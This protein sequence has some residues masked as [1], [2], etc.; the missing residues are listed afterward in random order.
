MPSAGTITMTVGADVGA[1]DAGVRQAERIYERFSAATQRSIDSV[2]RSSEALAAGFGSTSALMGGM[3]QTVKV[4]ERIETQTAAASRS[5]AGLARSLGTAA[6]GLLML[7]GNAE[8]AS[9]S[10]GGSLTKAFGSFLA[11]G[12]GV[13]GGVLAAVSLVADGI[14]AIGRN[15]AESAEKVT[16]MAS[17]LRDMKAPGSTLNLVTE[18]EAAQRQRELD[19]RA[20]EAG[21]SPERFGQFEALQADRARE[22]AFLKT[23]QDAIERLNPKL[24]EA[25]K[26][27]DELREAGSPLQSSAKKDLDAL[28]KQLQTAQALAQGAGSRIMGIDEQLPGVKQEGKEE[29]RKKAAEE[30]KKLDDEVQAEWLRDLNERARAAEKAAAEDTAR[31]EAEESAREKAAADQLKHEADLERMRDRIKKR[32]RAAANDVEEMKRATRERNEGLSQELQLRLA[33]TDMERLQLRHRFEYN[34]ELSKGTDMSAVIEIH[35]RETADLLAAQREE[36][37]KLAD[38]EQERALAHER[39][40][41]E[42]KNRAAAEQEASAAIARMAQ[43]NAFGAGYGPLAQARD[44]KKRNSNIARFKNHADNLR[45]ESPLGYGTVGAP[46][47]DQQGNPLGTEYDP[48][49]GAILKMGGAAD[50]FAFDMGSVFSRFHNPPKPR[51]DNAAPG[52]LAPPPPA[53]PGDPAGPS[54]EDI[55]G[56]LGTASDAMKGAADRGA[57]AAQAVGEAADALDEAAGAVEDGADATDRLAG[58]TKDLAAAVGP[59]FEAARA[60]AEEALEIARSVQ[61]LLES[62]GFYGS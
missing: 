6:G 16:L 57:A 44:A 39:M 31:R 21:M 56:P 20:A 51:Y 27:Y 36:T 54:M 53:Q 2:M 10:I 61:S 4:V 11:G 60:T 25:R 14:S 47:F 34:A 38:A 1:L 48:E 33:S 49:S 29:F 45:A 59:A 46:Q 12:G 30:Q 37:E 50:P 8:G 26:L 7:S 35:A 32:D 55:Y 22:A 24:A 42:A 58:A 62:S 9:Q 41:R 28:E 15:A 3:T 23:Q 40:A 5:T 19:A 17:R 18:R 13:S 43:T 52:L